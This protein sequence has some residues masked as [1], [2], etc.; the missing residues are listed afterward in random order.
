MADIIC[1]TSP[2][3]YLHQLGQLGL[4][5]QLCG[6]IIVP[7]AVVDELRVGRE[8][9]I[10]VPEPENIDWMDIQSPKSS[11][12]L[13]LV[14]DFGRGEIEV[15]ALALELSNATVI[16]DDKLARQL[17]ESLNIP[18]TGTL[19]VLIQSKGKGLITEVKPFL[20]RLDALGFRLAHGTQK[21][22]LKMV[23]EA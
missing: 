14:T 13:P 5:Q 11:V 12:V 10:D 3:Q 18:L 23:N 4:L 20:D 16:L 7:T 9:G 15:L 17:A 2:L 8:N 6:S 19:G 22:I 21:A 1:N